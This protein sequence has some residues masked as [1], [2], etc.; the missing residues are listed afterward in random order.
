MCVGSQFAM[1]LQSTKEKQKMYPGSRP[2]AVPLLISVQ[3]MVPNYSLS[4]I[5]AAEACAV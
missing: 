2:N 4:D 3:S 5:K 1:I